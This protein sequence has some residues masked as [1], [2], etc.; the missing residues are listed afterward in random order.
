MNDS[1]YSPYIYAAMA[2]NFQ[3]LVLENSRRGPV[4]VNFWS[5]SAGPCLHQ[6]P[7][8]D[9]LIHQYDGR[10]LLIN[11]DADK[12]IV[13][14]KDYGVTSVPTLKLFRNQQVVETLH[15]YQ[16][17]ADLISVLT[18]Y[19]AR[20]SDMTL[21]EA[22]QLF[23]DGKSVEAYEMIANAIVDDPVNYRLPLTMCK[24][25]K[26]EERFAEAIRLIETLP[27]DIRENKEIDQ[28]YDLLGFF[29]E[30][31]LTG[32]V[33]AL[34]QHVESVPDDL[35]AKRQ[36]A[37][38]YVTAQ[39]FEKALQQL[40]AIMELDHAYLENYPQKAMLKI[41]NILGSE[42]KLIAQYRPNLNRYIH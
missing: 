18:P 42:N 9:K 31:D 8:L 6:Y 5:S 10:V 33:D 21:A 26:H 3:S 24:L 37:I 7:F 25:L 13:I 23:A 32:D 2:E 30:A 34:I 40:V 16:S 17:E 4:L 29:A 20:D 1:V 36:L 15:G 38:Q 12:E 39:E 14:S 41:F 27:K 35:R 28:F 19:V 11:V 22:V